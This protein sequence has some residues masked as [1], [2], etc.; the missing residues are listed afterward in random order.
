MRLRNFIKSLVRLCADAGAVQPI[1]FLAARKAVRIADAAPGGGEVLN[2]LALSP[3]RFT[4]DL[5]AL[6]ASGRF[7][8]HALPEYYQYACLALFDEGPRRERFLERFLRAYRKRMP[9]DIV[10]GTSVWYRQDIPWGAAAQRAGIPYVILHKE[11]FKP[12]PP[13]MQTTV[14]KA[15]RFGAFPGERLIVHN[16]PVADAFAAGGYA[17]AERISVCGAMRM[18]DFVRRAN[19]GEGARAS[20]RA[21]PLVTY[22]SFALGIGLDDR[23][24]SPFPADPSDGWYELFRESHAAFARLARRRP[25]VDFVIKTKWH[26]QWTRMIEEIIRDSGAPLEAIPNLRV[27]SS[28]SAHDLIYDSTV[29]CGFGST[30]MLEAGLTDKPIVVPHFGEVDAPEFRG[31][32]KLEDSYHLFDVA[33][34]GAAFESE[35]ERN[36]TPPPVAADVRAA[37]RELFER[38]VSPLDGSAMDCY[39]DT[40][41]AI[42]RRGTT[43]ASAPGSA[44]EG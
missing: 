37:R 40:L 34:S 36:L 19:A 3:E 32:V 35:I 26:G 42:A 33:R 16:R 43:V 6:A 14:D 38:W 30:T 29:V 31:R 24:V 2:V 41:S 22:F 12:E 11:C 17:P 44:T 9:F 15:L 18:D 28:G 13:Q 4:G 27:D 10:L 25:D 8:V 5:R 39:L 1:A 20:Q 7:A 23:G 21:R